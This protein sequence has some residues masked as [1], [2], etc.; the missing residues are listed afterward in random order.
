MGTYTII[1]EN[2]LNLLRLG[3]R[4]FNG[5][6]KALKIVPHKS[7]HDSAKMSEVYV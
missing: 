6:K 2:R 4:T 5:I 3:V 7:G 1:E